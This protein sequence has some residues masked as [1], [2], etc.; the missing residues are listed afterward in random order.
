LAHI[1]I[2]SDL[3]GGLVGALVGALVGGGILRLTGMGRRIKARVARDDAILQ[4][5]GE[6]TGADNPTGEE[7]SASDDKQPCEPAPNVPPV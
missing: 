4:G 1:P 3:V 7:R 2:A 5:L 6:P